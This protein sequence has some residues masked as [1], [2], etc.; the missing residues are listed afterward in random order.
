MDA[1]NSSPDQEKEGEQQPSELPILSEKVISQETSDPVPPL[2]S[3]TIQLHIFLLTIAV[4]ALATGSRNKTYLGNR[5]LSTY[6]EGTSRPR[7]RRSQVRLSSRSNCRTVSTPMGVVR[8]QT[9]RWPEPRA[10]Q[11]DLEGS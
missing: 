8:V 7:T 2:V 9:H 4:L 1:P 5:A 3:E 11:S 10:E 6:F